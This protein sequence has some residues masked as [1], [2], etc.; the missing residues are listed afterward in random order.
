MALSS[1]YYALKGQRLEMI[2]AKT[3]ASKVPEQSSYG[4]FGKVTQIPHCLKKYKGGTK[5]NFSKIVQKVAL[6]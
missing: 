6:V 5:G 4:N 2:L 1:N 3:A